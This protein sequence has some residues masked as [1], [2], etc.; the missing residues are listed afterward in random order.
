MT[1]AS[2]HAPMLV[3]FDVGNTAYALDIGAVREVLRPLPM[4]VPPHAPASVVGVCDHRGEIV[5]VIDLRVHFGVAPGEAP[6]G[7][8]EERFIVVQRAERL[9]ALVVDRVSDV[10]RAAEASARPVPEPVIT[11]RHREIVA[12]HVHRTRLSFVLDLAVLVDGILPATE[13][14]RASLRPGAR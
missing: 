11:A 7:K 4:D 1:D 9:L 2:S 6:F 3:A 8:R 12:A 13:P 5:P 10:F 14:T